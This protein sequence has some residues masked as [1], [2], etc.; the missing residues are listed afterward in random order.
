MISSH[1][2]VSLKRVA[3]TLRSD[4]VTASEAGEAKTWTYHLYSEKRPVYSVGDVMLAFSSTKMENRK[5]KRESTKLL[6]TNAM[7]LSA[8][9]VVE[10]Y[11]VRWQMS[12]SLR[13]SRVCWGCTRMKK[14]ADHRVKKASREIWKRQ[15]AFGLRQAVLVGITVREHRWIQKRT[16][17]KHGLNPK[18][19]HTFSQRIPMRSLIKQSKCATSKRASQ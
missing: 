14:L 15:R 12:C 17:S 2:L 13:T 18:P 10:L 11:R 7:H 16:E 8:R 9:D 3:S 1:P 4:A 19:W 5:P 6:M